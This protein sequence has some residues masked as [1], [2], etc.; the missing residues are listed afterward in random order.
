MHTKLNVFCL[1]TKSESSSMSREIDPW[2]YLQDDVPIL[3][4][5]IFATGN[6]R[7]T[8]S[9]T[10]SVA[11]IIILRPFPLGGV[12]ALSCGHC[13]NKGGLRAGE[14]NLMLGHPWEPLLGP[15]IDV[16]RRSSHNPDQRLAYTMFL[17][18]SFK[19]QLGTYSPPSSMVPSRSKRP[20]QYPELVILSTSRTPTTIS[21]ATAPATEDVD[22]DTQTEK[23]QPLSRDFGIIPIPRRLR[24]NPDIPFKFGLG[25]N[26]AFGFASTFAT[27]EYG[28][29][30][31]RSISQQ[32]N[33]HLVQFSHS[34]RVTYGEVSRYACGLLLI[35]PLGDLVR[36]RQLMLTIVTLSTSLTIGLAVTN[37]FHVFQALNFLV[38]IV[39]V[40]PQV[41]LPLAAD[42]APPERR[43]SA[44][45][46][47]LSGLLFGILMARVLAGIIAEFASW[48]VVYYFAI[49]VQSAVLLGCYLMLPDYPSKNK[50][51]TYFEILG[52]MGKFAVTEPILIQATLV[53]M[54]SSACFTN[55]W[56]TLTF[57]LGGPPYNYSTL[58]IGLFGL[59]GMAGVAFGPVVGYVIDRLV[60][61]YASLFSVFMSLLFQGIQTGAGG[62]NVGAV[63]VTAFG[64]DVFRQM[65]QVSLTTAAFS[66]NAVLI[67]GIFVGQV[68][69]TSVGTHLFVTYGW[70]SAAYLNLGWMGLQIF[71]LLIRGPHCKRYT[72]FGHEGGLSWRKTQDAK[73]RTSLEDEEVKK[74]QE[75][76][77]ELETR[78][79]IPPELMSG[80]QTR[81]RT[82]SSII[83]KERD[84]SAQTLVQILGTGGEGEEDAGKKKE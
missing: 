10:R 4:P 57:L 80:D 59:I 13:I 68:M 28:S 39:S 65:L 55:F 31:L 52:T 19:L 38:G 32:L 76:G 75:Q 37:S 11:L 77:V 63:I 12:R 14:R 64:L 5:Q 53:N 7:A 73:E 72:W 70:R 62:I 82:V 44:I 30:S 51:L 23:P 49:S 47:V 27:V 24:Y 67:L 83:A 34:F 41:L 2:T 21:T 43:A 17:P 50:D 22:E 15:S 20:E 74:R 79:P 60:P 1:G 61:W 26:I 40:T 69:G 78:P 58:V 84:D 36:R 42:L 25:L 6:L 9:G 35:A 54:A 46:V 33:L 29:P 81:S 48:R 56:V 66:L 45:S 18:R 71:L 16:S 3:E 8:S